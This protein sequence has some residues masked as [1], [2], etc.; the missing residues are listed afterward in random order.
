MACSQ[1]VALILHSWMLLGGG[2]GAFFTFILLFVDHNRFI[3]GC[4]LFYLVFLEHSGHFNTHL[5]IVFL[6]K[7]FEDDR[8]EALLH[9]IEIQMKHQS[10]SF[11]LALTSVCNSTSQPPWFLFCSVLWLVE[12]SPSWQTENANWCLITLYIWTFEVL[13]FGYDANLF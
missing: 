11:G 1:W 2:D 5:S 4:Y 12:L 6:R 8:I 7:G 10:T 3:F 13:L 9:K